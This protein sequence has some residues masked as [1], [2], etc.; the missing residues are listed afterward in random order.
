MQKKP[1]RWNTPKFSQESLNT[2]AG[3]QT[4][5]RV[6]AHK[7]STDQ[8]FWRFPTIKRLPVLLPAKNSSSACQAVMMKLFIS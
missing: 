4:Y 7:V 6:H 8:D 1:K 3:A 5:M 2:H